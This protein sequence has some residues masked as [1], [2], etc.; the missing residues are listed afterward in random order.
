MA[1]DFA[2]IRRDYP[3]EAEVAKTVR[4][5]RAGGNKSGVC[6]FHPDKS[7]S[8]VVYPDNTFHCFG[9]GAHGDVIDYVGK[10]NNLRVTDA[11]GYLTGNAAPVL[12]AE[13]RAAWR[14]EKERQER[15]RDANMAAA[16]ATADRRWQKRVN[17]TT[18]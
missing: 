3:L 1:F 5:R 9:C 13:D 15:E 4:L 8:F 12:D 7:P 6:P 16:S 10:I 2:A 17:Q 11:I 14:I 18:S